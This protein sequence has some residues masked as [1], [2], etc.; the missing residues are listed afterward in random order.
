MIYNWQLLRALDL[1]PHQQGRALLNLRFGVSIHKPTNWQVFIIIAVVGWGGT[2]LLICDVKA[3]WINDD[4]SK[5]PIYLAYDP[6]T[7]VGIRFDPYSHCIT[8]LHLIQNSLFF[9][10][11]LDVYNANNNQPASAVVGTI[12]SSR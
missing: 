3:H 7:L 5:V 2:V 8:K 4:R 12:P 6:L 9:V 11:D 1:L 10:G